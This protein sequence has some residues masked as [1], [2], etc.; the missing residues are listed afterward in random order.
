M[1]ND[2]GIVAD[3]SRRLIHADDIID[4]LRRELEAAEARNDRM[5]EQIASG[6]ISDGY[7]THNELYEYRTLYN[8]ALFN[9]WAKDNRLR[10]PGSSPEPVKSHRHSDGELCF[11]G[12]AWFIVVAELPTG[13]ISNHY[14]GVRNWELF[15]IPEV[16]VP[17]TY[18]GH[19][20]GLA[21]Q[22]LRE[23]LR[24]S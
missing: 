21:A 9:A 16:D 7:H 14:R 5:Q 18:D 2:P 23:Y 8:A 11:G 1:S 24:Q 3:A 22:R 17:P 10:G 19:D 4:S 12:N 13:Q 15:D 20:P 6:E